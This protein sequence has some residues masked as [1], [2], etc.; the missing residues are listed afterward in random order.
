MK[1]FKLIFDFMESFYLPFRRS[2][3]H[4]LRFGQGPNP[5]ICLHG[6]GE[7][8]ES[9]AFLERSAGHLYTYYA[10]DLPFHGQTDWKDPAPEALQLR[11]LVTGLTGDSTPITLIGF[12][13]GGRVALSLYQAMPEQIEKLVL[14]APDGLKLNFWYWLSTQNWLGN[15]LF[16]FT[17]RKPHWFLGFVKWLNK[18]KLINASIFKFVNYYI[19]DA[20]VRQQLYQRWTGL[21]RIRPD[22]SL[23]KE[24]INEQKTPVKL[25]YG[26][27]DRIILSSVGEKFRK[28]I[29]SHAEITLIHAGHQ[30][31]QEKYTAELLKVLQS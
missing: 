18:M 14:L 25:V 16:A 30:L 8:A 19:G 13:L 4:C 15:H 24:K 29:E 2:R 21:R 11:E 3:I 31:L 12:S 17:M 23:I 20:Q 27:F 6:Y 9:F 28:N 10:L 1:E 5:A 7:T 26:K 22:L